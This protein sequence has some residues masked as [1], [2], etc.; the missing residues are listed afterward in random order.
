VAVIS[1]LP[2]Q[3]GAAATPPVRLLPAGAVVT[4]SGLPAPAGT[5][6]MPPVLLLPAA[7]VA[8]TRVVLVLQ[9]GVVDLP[10]AAP[11]PARYVG[12]NV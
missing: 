9:V 2:A 4:I 1:G 7:A 6:A 8:A 11:V 3:A 12:D 10:A 5:A